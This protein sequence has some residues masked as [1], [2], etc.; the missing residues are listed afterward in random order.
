MRICQYG[1]K[2]ESAFHSV[3]SVSPSFTLALSISPSFFF[4]VPCLLDCPSMDNV[5]CLRIYTHTIHRCMWCVRWT[6]EWTVCLCIC[7]SLFVIGRHLSHIDKLLSCGWNQVWNFVYN[8][9]CVVRFLSLSLSVSFFLLVAHV[10]HVYIQ[11]IDPISISSQLSMAH[12]NHKASPHPPF[13]LISVSI[14]LIFRFKM[15]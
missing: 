2:K 10:F 4:D 11:F 15:V 12:L 6:L 5:C 9:F 8:F 7:L 1:D 3:Q 13:H 14:H